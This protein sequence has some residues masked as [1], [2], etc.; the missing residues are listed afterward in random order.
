MQ[1][2]C[3]TATL[4]VQFGHLARED[5]SKDYLVRQT[6]GPFAAL[7]AKSPLDLFTEICSPMGYIVARTCLFDDKYKKL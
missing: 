3:D 7:L 1:R 4:L 5:E 2:K 6:A